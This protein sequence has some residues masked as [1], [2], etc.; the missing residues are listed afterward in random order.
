MVELTLAR[1][2]PPAD[3]AAWKALVE[4]A[5]KGT[6][7]ASLRS[8]SYDGIAIEPL[9]P[10]AQGR[11]RIVGRAAG[12]PWAVTQRIDMPDAKAANTQA[13]DDLGNGANALTLV[14][15]GSVRRLWLRA[16]RDR[17]RNQPSPRQC[18]SRRRHRHRARPQRAVEG[19]GGAS[20][21]RWSRRAV[22]RQGRDDPLRL[23]PYRRDRH[24]RAKPPVW[25]DIAPIFA[26]LISDLAGQ[27]FAGPFAVADGRRDPRRGRLGG[28]GARLHAAQARSPICARWSKAASR[29]TTRGR[30]IYFRLAADQD[31]FLTI[32]KFR[33]FG[34][35]GRA[36]SRLAGSSPAPPSSPP[37]PPG[38]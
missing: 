8:K 9:Y 19:R 29:S 10:R 20:S 38:A 13:L 18:L 5:L 26:G 31:Q 35:S 1:N 2:F 27:D 23:R 7:F 34:S 30:F 16:A 33:A 36:S 14:F 6:P 3:E 21:R 25:T 24:E 22:S 11:S 15:E 28:A 32:A 4:E 17:G 12:A 37:R